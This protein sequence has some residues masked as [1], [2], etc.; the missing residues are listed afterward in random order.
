[1]IEFNDTLLHAVSIDVSD[2]HGNR[3]TLNF[4]IRYYDSLSKPSTVITKPLVIAPNMVSVVEKPG[5]EM[6]ISDKA[7]SNVSLSTVYFVTG[8]ASPYA[9]SD[10]HQVGEGSVPVHDD[11][12]VRLKLKKKVP[13]MAG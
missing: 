2:A 13:I 8:S 4:M 11:M 10:I 5:F 12:V 9:F 7:I 6:Y 3:S 1:M